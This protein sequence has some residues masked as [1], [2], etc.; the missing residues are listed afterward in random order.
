MDNHESILYKPLLSFQLFFRKYLKIDLIESIRAIKYNK[1]NSSKLGSVDDEGLNIVNETG[2]SGSDSQDHPLYVD[3]F[4]ILETVNT[5]IKHICFDAPDP[6]LDL[7]LDIKISMPTA[8]KS[9][10]L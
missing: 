7:P 4:E 3:T 9:K 5:S 6:T 1:H 10:A 8:V 2:T